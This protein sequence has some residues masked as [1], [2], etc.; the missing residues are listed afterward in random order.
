MVAV[1]MKYSVF[2]DIMP[3]SPLKVSIIR[4]EDSSMMQVARRASAG[5][6]LHAGFLLPLFF[7]PED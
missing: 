4:V 2:W 3:C 7:D 6:L 1:L 5:Y